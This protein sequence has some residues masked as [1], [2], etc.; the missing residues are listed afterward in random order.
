MIIIKGAFVCLV[1]IHSYS[2]QFFGHK[3]SNML[4]KVPCGQAA[5]ASQVSFTK[6]AS[7][8]DQLCKWS[9]SW[10]LNGQTLP[11]CVPIAKVQPAEP[12]NQSHIAN[13]YYLIYLLYN[14]KAINYKSRSPKSLS[15]CTGCLLHGLQ[16]ILQL[17]KCCHETH[18]LS[19]I[20]IF[21]QVGIC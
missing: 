13:L 19:L 17:V 9:S 18:S 8:I 4:W 14:S 7:D 6:T 11:S 15:K 2:F 1:Y 5:V 21:G 10:H 12:E 16:A 20:C 3:C